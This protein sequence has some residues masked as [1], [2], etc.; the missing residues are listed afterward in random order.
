MHNLLDNDA[1]D[2]D[3]DGSLHNISDEQ[4]RYYTKYFIDL[5]PDLSGGI[6]GK[7]AKDFFLKSGLVQ[8][9]LASIWWVVK[10]VAYRV[11]TSVSLAGKWS[12][13]S[14][15]AIFYGI[16]SSVQCT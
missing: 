15:R 6:S 14:A 5:Q 1:L 10:A 8:S 7:M 12:I 11:S 9:E 4:V 16:N 3:V 2:D 13:A